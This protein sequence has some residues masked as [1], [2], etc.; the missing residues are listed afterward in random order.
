MPRPFCLRPIGMI[1]HMTASLLPIQ[2]VGLAR[3]GALVRQAA[4]L[5]PAIHTRL[6]HPE[7]PSRFG[8]ASTASDNIHDPLAQI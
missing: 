1:L 5:E 6:S 2:L 7:S 8:L 4:R 3:A